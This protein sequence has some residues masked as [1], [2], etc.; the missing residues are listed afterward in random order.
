MGYRSE[1][2]YAIVF[3][4]K[5]DRDKILN[6]LTQDE[7]IEIQENALIE[8]DRVLFHVDSIKWYSTREMGSFGGGYAEIDAHD[9]LI[10]AARDAE[11]LDEDDPDWVYSLGIFLRLG[12][13][14]NDT[15]RET[16][17]DYGIPEGWPDTWDLVEYNRS[18]TVSWEN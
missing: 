9:N 18:M 4:D 5:E 13:Q 8:E 17:G 15:E 2:A 1:V 16:W 3:K 11:D 7:Q 12:E 10:Q 14:D 6:K